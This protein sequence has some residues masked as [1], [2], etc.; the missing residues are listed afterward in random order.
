[1]SSLLIRIIAI[2]I[3]LA[4]AA[5]GVLFYL[6]NLTPTSVS[7]LG[8]PIAELQLALWLILFFT[9]GCVLGWLIA[10]AQALKYRYQ[11][12]RLQKQQDGV[13]ATSTT[14]RAQLLNS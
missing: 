13:T 7:V 6:D 3:L 9:S 14:S 10:S 8:K 11:L 2:F 4:G 5:F 1:M 12:S